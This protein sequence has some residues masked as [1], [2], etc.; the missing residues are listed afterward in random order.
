MFASVYSESSI[1]TTHQY[2][3]LLVGFDTLIYRRYYDT[4]LYLWVIKTIFW[5]R[6]WGVKHYWKVELVKETFT[7]SD[8][9]I[10][11]YYFISL[12]W[13]LHLTPYLGV[14]LTLLR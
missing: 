8:V 6:F 10:Y 13:G 1:K 5:P 3:L 4:P 14:V 2:L 7:V 12:C 9:F 11:V